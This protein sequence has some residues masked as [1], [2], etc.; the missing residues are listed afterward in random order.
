MT[1][2][3]ETQPTPTYAEHAMPPAVE[4]APPRAGLLGLSL[5]ALSVVVLLALVLGFVGGLASHALFPA[6]QG[7]RGE[8]GAAGV[9]GKAGATGPA[10]PA[11]PAANVDLASLGVCVN[12][13]YGDS[14]V[15]YVS[16]VSISAPVITGGTQQ[17]P[18]RGRSLRL[19]RSPA[20]DN[21]VNPQA[22]RRWTVVTPRTSPKRCPPMA[23]GNPR[24]KAFVERLYGPVMG[25][26]LG[27]GV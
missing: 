11:G 6:P 25:L 26:V 15:S 12:V 5:A 3:T 9:P 8:T 1:D 27:L 2:T 13:T 21:S 23:R 22:V 10:G 16:G 19:R 24:R 20:R 14:G 7:P 18:L 4:P 17:P